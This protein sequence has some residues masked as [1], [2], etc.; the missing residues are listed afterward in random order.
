MEHLAR[1]R[2]KS[3]GW[4][5]AGLLAL[6]IIGQEPNELRY[7]SL[8]TNRSF[9][10]TEKP[11]VEAWTSGVGALE[12]RVYRVKDPLA[13][14]E[15][16]EDPHS[17]GGQVPPRLNRRQSWLEKFRSWKLSTRDSIRDSFRYQFTRPARANIR[18]FLDGPPAKR[19]PRPAN[20]AAVPLLNPSQLVS[21]FR[22]PI[23]KKNP[24]DN[25]NVPIDVQQQPGL[26]IIE[27]TN[28]DL[29][30]YTILSI[31]KTALITKS[32]S[33][34]IVN[35]AVDRQS[36]APLRDCPIVIWAG[37]REIFRGQSDANGLI[38][39]KLAAERPD[40]VLV[41]AQP[42][43]DFAINALPGYSFSGGSEDRLTGYV[44]TDRPIYRPG[45]PVR[46]RAIVRAPGA[47]G[48][49]LPSITRAKIE[50]NDSDGKTV[51]RE[52]KS[53]S[54]FGTLDG[55][56]TLPEKAALGYYSLDLRFGDASVSGNFEVQEYKK[57]EYTVK[58]TPARKRYLQGA[59]LE[60]E[61]ESRYY[62]G[63]P[64]P[65]AKVK[66]VVYRSRYYAPWY[67]PDDSGD[68][69][70]E[71]AMWAQEELSTNSGV[72]N[73]EGKLSIRLDNPVNDQRYDWLYRIEA[74][75]TD[76]ANREITGSG[77]VIST[78]GSY[79]VTAFAQSYLNAPGS[80]VRLNVEAR[81]YDNQ[82]VAA[83]FDIN[84]RSYRYDKGQRILGDP[85]ASTSGETAA[86][87]RATPSVT[88][89]EP[90]SYIVQITSRTPEG[91]DLLH[92]TW[93][94]IEGSGSSLSSRADGEE[95]QIIP[96]KKQYRPGDTARF[97]ITTLGRDAHLLVT[98]EGRD[99]HQVKVQA[100][101][102]SSTTVEIP[103]RPEYAPNFYLTASFIRDGQLYQGTKSIKVPATER[104]LDVRIIP[105][106]AEFKP[107]EP[108][109]YA[110]ETRDSQG[111]PVAA[112]V[113][114][115]VV[116]EAIYA[117]R[118]E[119]AGDPLRFFYGR[120]YSV[121]STETSLSYYFNGQAGRRAFPIAQ[122]KRPSLGQ[123]KPNPPTE[124]K[125]RKAFPDTAFWQAAATTGPSGRA[126]VEFSFP[127]SL[128][129]WRATARGVTE[130]TRVGGAVQK[131]I[132][133]KNLILRPAVPRFFTE[134]DEITLSMI[135]NNYLASSKQ[136][137]ISLDSPGLEFLDG[138]SRDLSAPSKGEAKA[139]FRVRVK[140]GRQVVLTAKA[141]T[142]EESDAI[143]LTL[144]VKPFGI[145]L[146]LS[147]SGRDSAEF[148]L[149]IP[150]QSVPSSRTIEVN[151]APSVAGPIF[152]ALD[153]LTQF[154]YGCTEQT[155][156][157]LLPNIIV[158]RAFRDLGLKPQLDPA[159]LQA[160]VDAGFD[161]LLD[162]QHSDGGWGWWKTDDS[163]EFMTALVVEGLARAQQA[164]HST[165]ATETARRRGAEW[166]RSRFESLRDEEDL[167]AY[168]AYSLAVHDGKAGL[169]ADAVWRSRDRLAPQSLA[170]LGLA[171]QLTKD[172][173]ALEI[174]T[175]LE[176]LAKQNTD[177]AWWDS[178]EDRALRF[179]YDTSPEATAAALK[180]LA[181]AKPQSPLLPKAA[182]WLVAH[183]SEG[184]Y[185]HSTKQ[186]ALVV[187]ALTDY[188]RQSKELKPNFSV[189]VELNGK[190]IAARSFTEAD[191]AQ[192][193]PFSVRVPA[194][195]ANKLRVTKNGAGRLYW[196]ARAEYASTE[197]RLEKTGSAKLN[198]LRDY[199]RLVP[200]KRG[201][202]TV[203]RLEDAKGPWQIG[204]TIACR[205]TLT[206]NDWRYLLVEDPIPAGVEFITKDEGY[207][208]AERPDWWR[209]Y[210]TRREYRDDRAALFQTYF[211]RG[212]TQYVYLFKV[213]N[214]GK[215]K[216][217][218]ARVQP[219]Y[220]PQFLSTSESR[221]VEVLK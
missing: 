145:P 161:R 202:R 197:S 187:D 147:Q 28:G 36:G 73:A 188:V 17:F 74:R 158:S 61:I 54:K 44:Y 22:Q 24:W 143:E 39:A 4:L 107:G 68:P 3:I 138:K 160:K 136:T 85:V 63:E 131:V 120:V 66:Y 214:P 46:Y 89:A 203:Y 65:H 33:G 43:G 104:R 75:V 168:L 198:L 29:R 87:G 133:R 220:Q 106:K 19:A 163:S 141:I 84:V 123:L 121:V 112:E 14:F 114:L 86:D 185:W 45:H 135:A 71:G 164:G 142:D 38:D 97:L 183:R 155:M 49:R 79:L 48:Y 5:L 18:E 176:S 213:T 110:I 40:D 200:E 174:A 194:A 76:S 23:L 144:P 170:Q 181:Q 92:E 212:Q 59:P 137:K 124:P 55:E 60:A 57:P 16:L 217:S 105:S 27:A 180:L 25:V 172:A 139:D 166:L 192:P 199:F 115:G 132:V 182:Q 221:E 77:Y 35:Y 193:L 128:T 95:I 152:T 10:P 50:I 219:M 140:P 179:F 157:G 130:D 31:S 209:S 102:G 53:L 210:F 171:Y 70:L 100:A 116:D 69:D 72:L 91:R 122:L 186:T 117:I 80:P 191:L 2:S 165:P 150:A 211:D 62:F 175:R 178:G 118:E 15:Q 12:F 7:F 83:R 125:V 201:E 204:D 56:F 154:P 159:A 111:R 42:A 37:H 30:G 67:Q 156:S 94:W 47:L 190:E 169:F 151:L 20:F 134:G 146:Y 26:Y 153:Y 216:V 1:G 196:S 82:T 8:T 113:S 21:K 103:I 101:R 162:Y 206:G 41:M 34:R 98:T 173:R 177:E 148:A 184:F 208:M 11:F 96:D 51:Y 167:R 127:D 207:E 9:S 81:D 32:L 88:V 126:T 119:T 109:R 205:L 78:Y 129:T 52:F 149:N 64:V 90:G 58:V 13:F 218:P 99:L 108:A 215:F 195:L 6:P 189:S 93:L